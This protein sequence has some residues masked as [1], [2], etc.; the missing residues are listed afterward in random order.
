M[1]NVALEDGLMKA[2]N[3]VQTLNSATGM[4]THRSLTALL[5]DSSLS[6]PLV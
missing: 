1:R 2:D 6:P 5:I 4:Q 3:V